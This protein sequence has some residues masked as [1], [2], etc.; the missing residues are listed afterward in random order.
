M[1]SGGIRD[2]RRV[3][4]YSWSDCFDRERVCEGKVG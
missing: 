3:Q 4:K 2:T 1:E